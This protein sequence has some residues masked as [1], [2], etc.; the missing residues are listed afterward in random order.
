MSLV[1]THAHV[2]R[3]YIV[4]AITTALLLLLFYSHP[5]R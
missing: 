4:H 3:N 5:T 1:Y 2:Y